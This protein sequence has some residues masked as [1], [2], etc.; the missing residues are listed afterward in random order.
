M[1]V[2][3]CVWG[4][5]CTVNSPFFLSSKMNLWE[6]GKILGILFFY[7]YPE[8]E[9]QSDYHTAFLCN[10]VSI[11]VPILVQLNNVHKTE[12]RK[13]LVFNDSCMVFMVTLKKGNW[14]WQINKLLPLSYELGHLFL[15]L[16]TLQLFLNQN[17]KS[18]DAAV[19]LGILLVSLKT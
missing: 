15:H 2:T 13:L 17:F 3:V 14:R 5:G 6:L 7:L 8:R 18:W 19:A 12:R 1:C 10:L 4:G 16:F 11:C 9:E